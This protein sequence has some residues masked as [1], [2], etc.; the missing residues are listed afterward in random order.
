MATHFSKF[1]GIKNNMQKPVKQSYMEK[2]IVRQPVLK[3]KN[4][5]PA[6]K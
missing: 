4:L 5:H 3:E 6:V 1:R 2:M